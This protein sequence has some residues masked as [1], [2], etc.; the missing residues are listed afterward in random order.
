MKRFIPHLVIFAI[1]SGGYLG[2]LFSS[3]EYALTDLTFRLLPQPASE[4]IVVVEIDARSLQRLNVWPWPRRYHAA[5]VKRL[6]AAGAKQVAIDIDFS[7]QSNPEDDTQLAN[8]IAE[9]A[10][11]VVLPVF[12]QRF[13]R[14]GH[15]AE[16]I[17]SAPYEPFAKNAKLGTVNI[18][19]AEDGRVR[20]YMTADDW[21]GSPISSMAGVLATD[22][23]LPLGAF[24]VDY[25]IQPDSIPRLSYVDVIT[26]NFLN[27]TI[28]GKTVIIG[29]TAVELGDQ[30]SV[31]VYRVLPGPVVQAMAFES[32]IQ[33]RAIYKVDP[34][35]VLLI[36]L[37]FALL[38]G[39][40]YDRT[41][42]RAGLGLTAGVTLFSAG[43]AAG[44]F[45]AWPIILDTVPWI[46]MTLLSYLRSLWRSI[47]D[48]AISIFQHRAES[49]HR[50][51]MMSSVVDDSFDGIVITN[52]EGLI[53]LFNPTAEQILGVEQDATLGESIQ[54]L[55]P[56][57][58]QL[59]GIFAVDS[60]S[61]AADGPN[62]V[63]PTEIEIDGG[64]DENR[65]LELIVS[66]SRLAMAKQ[67]GNKEGLRKRVLIF[68]FRDVSERRKTEEAQRAARDM[69]EAANRA[70]TEFLAN[71]SHELRTPL[72][73]ILGFSE[74]MKSEALGPLG[75][76]QYL[77]YMNDI[78]NSGGHLIEI[79]NDILDMSKIEAGELQPNEEEFDFARVADTCARLVA[80]RAQIGTVHVVNEVSNDLPKIRAD[81]RMIKQ[82]LLNLLSNAVKFTPEDGKVT[83]S[84]KVS[85]DGLQFS[86]TDTGIGIPEDKMAIVLEPF[87][88]ADMTLQRQYEGTGLGLPLV[89]SMAE[90]H[91]GRLDLHSTEGQGTTA[92]IWLPVERLQGSVGTDREEV[93]ESADARNLHILIAEDNPINQQVISSLLTPLN[94]QLDIVE[95]GL[96]AVAAATRSTYDVILMDVHMPELDGL[97]AAKKIRALGGPTGQTPII[98][99]TA[100]EGQEHR[101]DFL[102]AGMDD[103]V[104]KPIDQL[105]LVK[106]VA[107][108]AN[109]PVPDMGTPRSAIPT[110]EELS[111]TAA[112]NSEAREEIADLMGDLDDLLDKT[113]T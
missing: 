30:L 23:P 31:P 106:S 47:D 12:K 81:Q 62:M 107:T 20:H 36:A 42:W 53:E 100:K 1:V 111:G 77:D 29:A 26:G 33:G 48:Q 97:G 54:D 64:D 49:M 50:R 7:S 51:A 71:M 19:L 108:C 113:G 3:L 87:G 63:G 4:K 6:F 105:A 68:T 80:D 85:S 56:W 34:K 11:R 95:N 79:I 92:S 66:S 35:P 109:V 8:A 38:I 101:R 17:H 75:S 91:G 46:L 78:H 28:A 82:I 73:A 52:E 27:D 76:P 13:A 24:F 59:D 103:F 86:V 104:A 37:L 57:S 39:P 93:A 10:G 25:S 83:L 5:V 102:E 14:P 60:D 9:A 21:K 89:K 88:Q 61:E 84:A 90:L 18:R 55:I 67:V 22:E 96:E 45:A 69:A 74:I 98:A 16:I 99:V 72:N 40:L 32:L 41:S 43:A 94:C 2:G 70:K 110:H 65:I 112:L 58:A 15:E 44:A